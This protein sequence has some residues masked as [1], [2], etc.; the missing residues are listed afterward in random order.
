[1]KLS[2]HS[3]FFIQCMPPRP[4]RNTQIFFRFHKNHQIRTTAFSCN[5]LVHQGT[6]TETFRSAIS[7]LSFC[8]LQ[9]SHVG[10]YKLCYL[11]RFTGLVRPTHPK[12]DV[13]FPVAVCTGE[14]PVN[15]CVTHQIQP[16]S[17]SSSR[18]L[19]YKVLVP[20]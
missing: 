14:P 13:P 10:L 5:T 9:K 12:Q 18:Y 4:F 7:V 11:P 16:L 20:C 6:P 3:L 17:P 8:N 1:M 2:Y 19:M 15:P